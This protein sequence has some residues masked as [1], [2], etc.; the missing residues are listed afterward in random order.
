MP[1]CPGMS[2]SSDARCR[3]GF[4]S[5]HFITSYQ[6]VQAVPHSYRRTMAVSSSSQP[7]RHRITS[8]I[9][10]SNIFRPT[11]RTFSSVRSFAH[12]V[13]LLLR[14]GGINR[15][16]GI[17]LQY[18]VDCLE[19]VSLSCCPSNATLYWFSSDFLPSGRTFLPVKLAKQHRTSIFNP[20]PS[21]PVSSIERN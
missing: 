8:T 4:I 17:A 11:Q 20:V 19:F 5:V 18:Y 6:V 7:E 10:I 2:G 9:S 16:D 14:G 1:P 3:E 21:S 15:R 12:L 13:A